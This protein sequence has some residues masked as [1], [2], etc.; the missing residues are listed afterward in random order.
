MNSPHNI[1]RASTICVPERSTFSIIM[2]SV[3]S[4]ND[5]V[6]VAAN[7]I[8]AVSVAA[9]MVISEIV[10]VGCAPSRTNAN[11][12]SS[13]NVAPQTVVASIVS[14][15][16][17]VHSVAMKMSIVSVVADC[18]NNPVASVVSEPANSKV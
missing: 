18:V 12:V 4:H 11:V 16:N 17:L 6:S 1:S 9:S 5:F 8:T 13:V 14:V 3:A 2:V 7:T 10:A 15:A